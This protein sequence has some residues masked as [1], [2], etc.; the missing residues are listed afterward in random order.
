MLC[1][2]LWKGVLSLF[3]LED[4]AE[5]TVTVTETL[6]ET[7]SGNSSETTSTTSSGTHSDSASSSTGSERV[8]GESESESGKSAETV[9]KTTADTAPVV[10]S[11]KERFPGGLDTAVCSLYAL[12]LRYNPYGQEP[13][14]LPLEENSIFP[15]PDRFYSATVYL[16]GYLLGGGTR[17]FDLYEKEILLIESEISSVVEP[18]VDRYRG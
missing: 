18:I 13:L 11:L 17:L 12:A 16:V 14:S 7:A 15:L 4:A 5:K 3:T 10:E 9:T 6:S 1:S 2:E 8:S